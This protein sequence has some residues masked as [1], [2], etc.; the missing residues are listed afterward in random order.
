MVRGPK[1][2]FAEE[3]FFLVQNCCVVTNH[4]H[5]LVETTAAC[6][7]ILHILALLAKPYIWP[8][9]IVVSHYSTSS[10][11]WS[12]QLTQLCPNIQCLL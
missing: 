7:T 4:T 12:S 10:D 8:H 2:R 5:S 3:I 6:A 11:N 9:G 1:D